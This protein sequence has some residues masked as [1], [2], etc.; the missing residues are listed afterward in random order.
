MRV[1]TVNVSVIV[2]VI[3]EGVDKEFF[4]QKERKV[5]SGRRS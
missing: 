3:D 5:Q 1:C 4:L 2:A